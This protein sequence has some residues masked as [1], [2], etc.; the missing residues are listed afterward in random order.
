MDKLSDFVKG[1]LPDFVALLCPNLEE[2][3][4]SLQI[5]IGS[6]ESRKHDVHEDLQSHSGKKRKREVEDW[7]NN[8]ENI[9]NDFETLEQGVQQ[10]SRFYHVFKRQ[11][12]AEQLE[13]MT[14][15]VTEL[16]A[17]GEFPSGHFLE[18][19]EGIDRL[20][21]IPE[22]N[23]QAFQQN[24]HD[25]WTSLMDENVV[26]IGIYGMGGVGKTTL[27]RH[28]HDKLLKESTFSGCVYWVTVSQEF[29]IY[30][31]QSDIAELL[32]P[33]MTL[34]NDEGRRAAKLFREFQKMERFVFILDDVWKRIDAEKIGIPSKKDGCKHLNVLTY[35]WKYKR[36]ARKW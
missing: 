13:R 16:F 24:F 25:I 11:K 26:S 36:F 35:L 7:M 2:N 9:I 10:S 5:K 33:K 31:L 1:I 34:E 19:D 30:K 17:Q 4:E 15:Q 12:L 18:V 8:V 27:A 28:V 22:P 6:L 32:D 21:L 20:L 14:A 23:G 29:S 3:T